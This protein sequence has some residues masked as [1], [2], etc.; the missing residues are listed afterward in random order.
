[1]S[2]NSENI[3]EANYVLSTEKNTVKDTKT[4]NA[5]TSDGN[6]KSAPKNKRNKKDQNKNVAAIVGDSIIKDVYGWKLSDKEKKMVVKHFSESTTEEMKT[7]IQPPLKRDPDRVII[8]VGTNDLRSSQDPVTIA[9]NMID[10]AKTSTTN[11]NETLVPSI[12]P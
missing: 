11:K 6:T 8:H 1:M 7:Y 2:E 9:K 12:V 4:N 10:T 5:N 3:L